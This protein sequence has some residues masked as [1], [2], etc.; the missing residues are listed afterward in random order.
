MA[1]FKAWRIKTT[2][3][4]G[5]LEAESQD[6]A[7]AFFHVKESGWEVDSPTETEIVDVREVGYE[8][9]TGGADETKSA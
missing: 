8:D 9:V 4:V 3:E 5:W 2:V 1:L 7:D 6:E